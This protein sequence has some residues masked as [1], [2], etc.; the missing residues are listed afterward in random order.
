VALGVAVE[1]LEWLASKPAAWATGQFLTSAFPPDVVRFEAQL[2]AEGHNFSQGRVVGLVGDREILTVHAALGNKPSFPGGGVWRT[3]PSVPPPEECDPRTH[4]GPSPG[5]LHRNMDQFIV[6]GEWGDEFSSPSGM[7]RMWMRRRHARIGTTL[8]LAIAADFLPLGVRAAFGRPL[9]GA[10]LDNTVR[11]LR[12]TDAEWI[13]ADLHIDEVAI[14]VG[15]GTVHLWSPDG[16]LLAIGSQT[17]SLK[18]MV[19]STG[20][21]PVVR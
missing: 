20:L 13:L 18:E 15:H 12:R 17:C 11:Y 8:G 4:F 10:S 5:L 7:T 2:V 16:E 6:A 3:M 9:F 14:G 21:R 19:G 1:Q